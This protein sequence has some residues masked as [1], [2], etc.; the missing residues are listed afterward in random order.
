MAEANVYN[1]PSRVGLETNPHTVD[2]DGDI[3]SVNECNAFAWKGLPSRIVLPIVISGWSSRQPALGESSK[4]HVA[5]G[6]QRKVVACSLEPRSCLPIK[7]WVDGVDPR[8]EL[9]DDRVRLSSVD[10]GRQ[11]RCSLAPPTPESVEP[12]SDVP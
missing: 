9:A 10:S 11:A 2:I 6:R 5:L 3:A 7:S 4:L 1:L 12:D 8:A